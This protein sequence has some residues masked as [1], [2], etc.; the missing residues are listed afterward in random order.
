MLR[1]RLQGAEAQERFQAF[2]RQF[3]LAGAPVASAPPKISEA[4]SVAYSPLPESRPIRKEEMEELLAPLPHLR[5]LREAGLSESWVARVLDL[6]PEEG[7][8]ES[9]IRYTEPLFKLGPKETPG[10]SWVTLIPVASLMAMG[11]LEKTD[12]A[13]RPQASSMNQEYEEATDAHRHKSGRWLIIH[14]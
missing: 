7:M 2:A 9:E 5:G 11:G 1:R 14:D 6:K 13:V 12:G 10:E 8:T 4:E 3:Q